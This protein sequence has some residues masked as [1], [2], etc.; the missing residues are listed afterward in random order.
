M[1]SFISGLNISGTSMF[2]TH[3]NHLNW[4]SYF[5]G[6]PL[7]EFDISGPSMLEN[8]VTISNGVC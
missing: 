4:G 8:I 5:L 6:F 3:S 1:I 2:S 7:K